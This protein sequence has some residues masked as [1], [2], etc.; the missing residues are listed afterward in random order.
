L[1]WEAAGVGFNVTD[2]S[3][4][5]VAPHSL[6]ARSRAEPRVHCTCTIDAVVNIQVVRVSSEVIRIGPKIGNPE[7]ICPA[8]RFGGD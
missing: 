1:D 6:H 5:V 8:F 2:A 3:D 4:F 7:P